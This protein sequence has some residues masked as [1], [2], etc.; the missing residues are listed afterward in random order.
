MHVE[1]DAMEDILLQLGHGSKISVQLQDGCTIPPNIVN[2]T[3][4][5]HA[6]IKLEVIIHHVEITVGHPIAVTHV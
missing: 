2:L 5:P 3:R 4:W 1:K 6:I